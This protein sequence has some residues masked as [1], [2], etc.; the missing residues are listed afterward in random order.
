M[1]LGCG[2]AEIALP[3]VPVTGRITLDSAPLQG[4]QVVFIPLDAGGGSLSAAG[5]TNENGEYT[6]S[7]ATYEGV[8]PGQY[9]VLVEHYTMPDGSPVQVDTAIGGLEQ[10][11]MLG[12]VRQVLPAAYTSPEATT[13]AVLVTAEKSQGYDFQ[14]TSGM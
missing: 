14:L 5:S 10:M 7:A 4:A 6:L 9:K 12:Q 1:A 13:L 8:V 3:T 11:K 2:D